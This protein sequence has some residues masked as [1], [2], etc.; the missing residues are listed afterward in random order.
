MKTIKTK[1][2]LLICLIPAMFL[3]FPSFGGR[4][5]SADYSKPEGWDISTL[6]LS[7]GVYR[8]EATG[9]REGLLVEVTIENGEVTSVEIADHN[10]IGPQF[11]QRPMNLV[12]KAIVDE[13]DTQVDG[14]SGATATSMAIM[15]AVEN[16]LDGARS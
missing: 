14:V 12:P 6:E 13:Q 9:F 2:A 1:K 10:E 8:G 4:L 7:D 11:Y 5:K 15:A 16:A 3:L